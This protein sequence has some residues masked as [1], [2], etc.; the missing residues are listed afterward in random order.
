MIWFL[1]PNIEKSDN[2]W[3]CLFTQIKQNP[4][5]SHKPSHQRANRHQ[6]ERHCLKGTEQIIRLPANQVNHPHAASTNRFSLHNVSVFFAFERRTHRDI[7]RLAAKL[8]FLLLRKAGLKSKR[9][10]RVFFESTINLLADVIRKW[11]DE[12]I[13]TEINL[14][15]QTRIISGTSGTV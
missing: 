11:V 9:A 6:F 7:T 1:V 3:V 2:V 4:T 8:F 12:S 10:V 13:E 14:L 15:I 5:L